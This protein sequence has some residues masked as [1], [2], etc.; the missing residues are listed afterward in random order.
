MSMTKNGPPSDA[1]LS[2]SW[3]AH[4]AYVVDLAY[5][6]LRDIG[7]AE[8]AVQEA[9][10]RLAQADR[11]EIQDERGWLVVVTSRICLDRVKSA[12]SRREKSHD[13][14]ALEL[15]GTA[16]SPSSPADPADRAALDD[17]VSNALVVVLEQ[18]GPAERVVFV[19]HDVFGWPF[20]TI[21]ETLGR[22]SAS[23]RQLAR[24]A[25]VKVRE[26][27]GPQAVGGQAVGTRAV[28]TRA[29]G[30]RAVGTRG[31][32]RRLTE[33]FIQACSGGDLSA[34]LPLL[35]AGVSGDAD[36]GPDD[37]R[38]HRVARGPMAVAR[39]LMYYFGAAA[40]MVSSPTAEGVV[41]AFVDRRL[42]GV[43]FIDAV[44]G[45]I[46]KVHVLADP[47]RLEALGRQC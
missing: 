6:M 34:L 26:H 24:R 36:L 47:D 2:A 27:P 44:G 13:A 25:R 5:S 19:L 4:R 14:A 45:L 3:R 12:Y 31:D 38:G 35:D 39:N 1:N 41:L 9:F 11:D 16:R 10:S 30:T 33:R 17:E 22:S 21:A 23:C 29:V 15:L 46:G 28:G 40:T 32:Y 20:A 42:Y 8:D 43:I 18:L 37:H 7:A